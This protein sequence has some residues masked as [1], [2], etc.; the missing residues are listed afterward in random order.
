MKG[1]ILLFILLIFPLGSIFAS[2]HTATRT[3]LDDAP[4]NK[5]INSLTGDQLNSDGS[6]RTADLIGFDFSSINVN[7]VVGGTI[8]GGGA[9]YIGGSPSMTA[10][11]FTDCDWYTKDVGGTYD[12]ST[13]L[14]TDTYVSGN[15]WNTISL[16][17]TQAKALV[18]GCG[19][20]A[21]PTITAQNSTYSYITASYVELNI[22]ENTPTPTPT[23]TPTPT[24]TPTPTPTGIPSPLNTFDTL[25]EN[26]CVWRILYNNQNLK[27]SDETYHKYLYVIIDGYNMASP[28][29]TRFNYDTF[30]RVNSSCASEFNTTYSTDHDTDCTIKDNT[31][32]PD[33]PAMD[34]VYDDD[35]I[36]F[37]DTNTNDAKFN[38]ATISGYINWTNPDNAR[39]DDNNYATLDLASPNASETAQAYFST[40]LTNAI[41]TGWEIKGIEIDVG[42]KTSNNNAGR[43][44]YVRLSKDYGQTWQTT[45]ANNDLLWAMGTGDNTSETTHTFTT[46]SNAS[47]FAGYNWT[48]RDLDSLTIAIGANSNTPV[49]ASVDYV[50][51]RAIFAQENYSALQVYL[52]SGAT[53]YQCTIKNGYTTMPELATTDGATTSGELTENITY[54]QESC[55]VTDIVCGIRN[56][57]YFDTYYAS[58]IFDN[59]RGQIMNVNPFFYLNFL[60]TIRFTLTENVTTLPDIS[61]AIP[62]LLQTNGVMET[63]EP[64]M[65][66]VQA[67]DIMDKLGTTITYARNLFKMMLTLTFIVGLVVFLKNVHL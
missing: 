53:E 43:Q 55:G 45:S 52:T 3:R 59:I 46:D 60:N 13:E 35:N 33:V 4:Y 40:E 58:S 5:T 38:T 65:F 37:Q 17:E 61:I 47:G 48:A 36:Y 7:Q 23:V 10:Y 6:N 2:T 15:L 56:F 26:S 22:S 27:Y 25:A 66:T 9:Y 12:F 64:T 8:H 51:V 49:L 31:L 42:A 24:A 67:S 11:A 14:G 30:E 57:F 18:N 28:T 32:F 20:V 50:T 54:Y 16:N 39:Y 19:F 21:I 63:L 34:L 41:P 29:A 62:R 1:I 44:L